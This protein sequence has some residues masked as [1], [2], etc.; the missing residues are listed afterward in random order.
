MQGVEIE[1][2]RSWVRRDFWF[3]EESTYFCFP[4]KKSAS[5]ASYII[6]SEKISICFD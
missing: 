2:D 3:S 1:Q 4:V 6:Y 5:L